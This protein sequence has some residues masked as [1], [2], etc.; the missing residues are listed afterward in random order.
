M[1]RVLVKIKDEPCL[2]TE[3]IERMRELCTGA[4]VFEFGSGGST[5]WLA[6]IAARLISVEDDPA[7]HKAVKEAL[8][9]HGYPGVE[10]KLATSGKLP[11]AIDGTGL[12]DVVFVDCW[13]QNGRRRSIFKGAPHVKPGGWLIA[14]DYNFPKTNKAVEGLRTAG[15]DV[16]IV[17]GIELHPLRNVPVKTSTAFCCKPR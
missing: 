15:W 9:N 8:L 4:D 11:D 7:W 3:A 17:S 1:V 16:S 10:V 2:V 5:V 6:R 13:T 14:D 12:W